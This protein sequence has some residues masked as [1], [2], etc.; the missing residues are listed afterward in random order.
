MFRE[1][2]LAK[3]LPQDDQ[4]R[5]VFRSVFGIAEGSWSHNEGVLALFFS[6]FRA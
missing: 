4:A 2:A 3:G 1:M 6:S 5:I